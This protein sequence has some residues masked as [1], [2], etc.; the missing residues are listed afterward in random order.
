MPSNAAQIW[1]GDGVV[2]R[3]N[4]A[5]GKLARLLQQ[6]GAQQNELRLSHSQLAA[7]DPYDTNILGLPPKLEAT[8]IVAVAGRID[9]PN[10]EVFYRL[11]PF[12]QSHAWASFSRTGAL[13]EVGERRYIMN[14]EQYTA[15]EAI[16]RIIAAGADV[17]ARLAAWEPLATA[18]LV[19][20]RARV[21]VEGHLPR[22]HLQRQ[23]QLPTNALVRHANQI[24]PPAA[25]ERWGMLPH[26][27]Y[28]LRANTQ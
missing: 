18:L 22:V 5:E 26:R 17:A 24:V 6:L 16:A 23:P 4:A 1:S 7:L 8:L 9:H 25:D 13:I 11:E 12:S 28:F 19:P 14:A 27:R 10:F 20:H 21:L 2:L 15:F 3:F